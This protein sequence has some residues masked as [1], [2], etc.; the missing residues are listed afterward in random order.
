MVTVELEALRRRA[1]LSMLSEMPEN[2]T[3]RTALQ[4]GFR[5]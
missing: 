4:K 3:D 5:V 1:A 2:W